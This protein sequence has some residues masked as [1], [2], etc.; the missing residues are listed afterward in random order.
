M[1]ALVLVGLILGS[2]IP[3]SAQPNSPIVGR[4]WGTDIYSPVLGEILT[5]TVTGSVSGQTQFACSEFASKNY[6]NDCFNKQWA[7]Y[8]IS[9]ANIGAGTLIDIT[10]YVSSTGVYTTAAAGANWAIGDDFMLIFIGPTA[11]DELDAVGSI[12]FPG[13]VTTGNDDDTLY[14][15]SWIGLGDGRFN[16]G[17]YLEVTYHPL[18][19][20]RREIRDI[21]NFTSTSG[22]VY[23]A[24]E[25]SDTVDVGDVLTI[26]HS[27][28]IAERLPGRLSYEGTA[29]VTALETPADSFYVPDLIG[30]GDDYFNHGKYWAHIVTTTDGAAPMGEYIPVADYVSN[31]GLFI[32]RSLAS[33]QAGFSAVITALDHIAI[34]H[35]S[36]VNSVLGTPE[37]GLLLTVSNNSAN[38]TT[39][40]YAERLKGTVLIDASFIGYWM[41]VVYDAGGAGAE[42]QGERRKITSHNQT[43]GAIGFDALT[44]A[45]GAKDQVIIYP[46]GAE[47]V[48]CPDG[49]YAITAYTAGTTNQTDTLTIPS[50]NTFFTLLKRPGSLINLPGNYYLRVVRPDE[51][52]DSVLA[53]MYRIIV[54]YVTAA[55]GTNGVV[56]SPGFDATGS[57]AVLDAGNLVEVVPFSEINPNPQVLYRGY[58]L[59]GSA[60]T[61]VFPDL[62]GREN[63]ILADSWIK[64]ITDQSANTDE[65]KMSLVSAFNPVTGTVTFTTGILNTAINDFMEIQWDPAS[66]M[67][68]G[69]N[70]LP[71]T[72]WNLFEVIARDSVLILAVDDFVDTE[73][74][75]IV[76]SCDTLYY[77][78]EQ[79]LTKKGIAFTAA[80][81]SI[82]IFTVTGNVWLLSLGYEVTTNVSAVADS[83]KWIADAAT[84]TWIGEIDDGEELNAVA[85]GTTMLVSS[86]T[87]SSPTTKTTSGAPVPMT[88]WRLFLTDG[89]VL[90]LRSK[91]ADA[92][93]RYQAFCTYISAEEGAKIVAN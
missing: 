36:V 11:L 46:G 5:G 25:F 70:G 92:T 58:A 28:A 41:K 81:D 76:G 15:E 21:T 83:V 74:A 86:S 45:V 73:V 37:R 39:V 64:C 31:T 75:T 88:P 51:D 40:L 22:M 6:G 1:L 9:A 52:A 8:V 32:A 20:P 10:D 67:I 12:C 78:H 18:T 80:D 85:A 53:G 14:C 34:V 63:A 3:V 42:P 48:L 68:G 71:G 57:T 13:R 77:E 19:A 33:T 79:P 61:A 69:A 55:D 38:S 27:S 23:V 90:K 47:D 54:D 24:D 49:V 93:G 66:E 89:T 7:I 26:W 72:G 43:T 84:G 50:L 82:A 35:E 17:Y 2:A 91:G 4:I 30:F 59:S 56:V 60:T 65:G 44:A 29:S 16:D 62:I 87:L